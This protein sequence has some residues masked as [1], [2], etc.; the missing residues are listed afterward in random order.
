MAVWSAVPV[1][2]LSDDFRLDAEHYQP[3]YLR[4]EKAMAKHE[5]VALGRIAD[6]FDGNHLS[7]AEEFV[8]T[9]V[10]YLRGQDLSDFFISDLDP[11]YIPDRFYAALTRS[12]MFA[13]DVLV[14]IVGTIGNVGLVTDRHGKLTGNCK[15]A[16]VRSHSLPAEYIATYLAS[17][18]G[19]NEIQRRIRGAVQMGLILP[20]LRKISIVKPKKRQCDAIVRLVKEAERRRKEARKFGEEAEGLVT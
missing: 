8:D 11:V 15:L 1:K 9:G 6:V 12:H 17:Q 14:S 4:Q 16:I 2:G 3:A 13:G 18:V 5:C 20:D 19:Q 7:I 10:R